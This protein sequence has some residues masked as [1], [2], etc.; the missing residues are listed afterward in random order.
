LYYAGRAG[1]G[2]FVEDDVEI[3]GGGNPA[4]L[5]RKLKLHAT[6]PTQYDWRLG[7]EQLAKLAL[8]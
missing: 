3:T 1:L 7:E 2:A 5:T 8:F 6:A 4:A